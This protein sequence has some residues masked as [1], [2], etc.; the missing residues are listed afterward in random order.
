MSGWFGIRGENGEDRLMLDIWGEV[1]FKVWGGLGGCVVWVLLS[2]SLSR[3][4]ALSIS[5]PGGG[6]T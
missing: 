6:L 3:F 2:V 5:Y 1:E 4:K